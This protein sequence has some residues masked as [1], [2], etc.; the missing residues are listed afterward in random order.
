MLTNHRTQVAGILGAP[1]WRSRTVWLSLA[2][3]CS[4]GSVGSRPRGERPGPLEPG[5]RPSA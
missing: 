4:L 3:A 2:I 1:S 5:A